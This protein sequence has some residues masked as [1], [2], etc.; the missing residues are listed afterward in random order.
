MATSARPAALDPI[1]S[2]LHT[3]GL[4]LIIAS[5]AI[6][7]RVLVAHQSATALEEFGRLRIYWIALASEWFLLVY[8]LWGLRR[9]VTTVRTVIDE[10]FWALSRLSLYAAIAVGAAIVW[11]GCGFVLGLVL[12]AQQ[13]DQIRHLQSLLPRGGMEKSL[14]VLLSASAGFCE[15]FL[16]RGYLQQQFR[17]LTGRLS[18]GI[19]LQAVVYGTA[20]AALPR[21]I[22]V[23][24][25]CLG[26]LLGA[27]AA[28]R[29]SL[30]PGMLLHA[31]LDIVPGLLSRT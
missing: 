12:P 11:L 7:G 16:Y 3:A 23:T 19:F 17:R 8:V 24:A 20:H 9:Q 28:W 29:R 21:E 13:P 2:R 4:L 31:V 1:A 10:S 25:M 30:V 18:A 6:A 15:E 5:F 27:L 22:V 14:W 26:L